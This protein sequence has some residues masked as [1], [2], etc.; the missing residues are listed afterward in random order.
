MDAFGEV[1]A[2]DLDAAALALTETTRACPTA[3][4]YV[5]AVK[6]NPRSWL[7]EKAS[8]VKEDIVLMSACLDN[9]AEPM[10]VDAKENDLI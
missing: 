5:A 8:D 9:A 4:E 10:C 1:P 2:D 3:S 6:A 7:Y